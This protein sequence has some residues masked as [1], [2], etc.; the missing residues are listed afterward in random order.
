MDRVQE[1]MTQSTHVSGNISDIVVFIVIRIVL[2]SFV[3]KHYKLIIFI[4]LLFF[5]LNLSNLIHPPFLQLFPSKKSQ[6]R[7]CKTKRNFT[8]IF[9]HTYRRKGKLK[10]VINLSSFFSDFFPLRS[11]IFLLF[12]WVFFYDI[13][14][15]LTTPFFHPS[16][17]K[18]LSQLSSLEFITIVFS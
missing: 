17:Q 5:L 4:F 11:F 3:T 6:K 10:T 14:L 15:L 2:S 13:I 1:M 8:Q 16:F 18:K 12:I 9:L 7:W